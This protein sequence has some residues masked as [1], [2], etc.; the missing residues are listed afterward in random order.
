MPLTSFLA[1]ARHFPQQYRKESLN[2][3]KRRHR[4]D[5]TRKE[6]T[7]E[8]ICFFCFSKILPTRTTEARS[9]TISQLFMELLAGVLALARKLVKGNIRFNFTQEKPR[10]MVSINSL[11]S[12]CLCI[13]RSA[14]LDIR[15]FGIA[16]PPSPSESSSFLSSAG[17]SGSS[18]ALNLFGLPPTR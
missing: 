18:F 8:R 13:S 4:M 16:L 9:T 6:R 7:Q 12:L 2:M 10:K 11:K 5:K 14:S 3:N 17:G 1:V 15:R